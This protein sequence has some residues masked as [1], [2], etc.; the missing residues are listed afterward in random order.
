MKGER[1]RR[2][3]SLRRGRG[4]ERGRGMREREGGRERDGERCGDGGRERGM[5]RVHG[6]VQQFIKEV[7]RH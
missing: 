5:K 6:K 4:R 3:G 2:E 1:E 7:A